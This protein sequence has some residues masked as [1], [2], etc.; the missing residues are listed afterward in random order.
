MHGLAVH[1]K[2]GLPFAQELSV[3]NSV[4]SYLCFWLALPHSV[5]YFF[6]LY[7]SPFSSLCMVFDSISSNID[8]A[9]WI[10]KKRLTA[11]KCCP[12]WKLGRQKFVLGLQRQNLIGLLAKLACVRS[13]KDVW[14]GNML[15]IPFLKIKCMT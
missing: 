4:D 15:F 6:F 5:S 9:L 7:Q 13:K 10:W 3:E 8:A 14:E 11:K 1:V 12:I 2:D